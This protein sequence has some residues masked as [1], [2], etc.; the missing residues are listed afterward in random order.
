MKKTILFASL[1]SI[2]MFA[3]C[4]HNDN[5]SMGTTNPKSDIASIIDGAVIDENIPAYKIIKIADHKIFDAVLMTNMQD[6]IH[7]SAVDNLSQ[8][9]GY[10]EGNIV[11]ITFSSEN[12]KKDVYA[13]ENYDYNYTKFLTVISGKWLSLNNDSVILST[14]GNVRTNL[15]QKGY[16]KWS[17]VEQPSLT[18]MNKLVLKKQINSEKEIADTVMI[19]MDRHYMNF[20]NTELSLKYSGK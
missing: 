6:T 7:M 4:G 12:N 15:K 2:I 5:K 9:D 11:K 19:N 8:Y 1:V 20:M 10:F 17:I 3:G 14:N 13:I 16:N 18:G